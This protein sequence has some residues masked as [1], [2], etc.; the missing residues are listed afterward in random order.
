MRN[1]T[2]TTALNLKSTVGLLTIRIKGFE[3][4]THDDFVLVKLH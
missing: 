1:I 3:F 4:M 2:K